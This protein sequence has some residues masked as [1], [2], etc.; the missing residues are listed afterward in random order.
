M[1][2]IMGFIN[3]LRG[4]CD[5]KPLD[6]QSWSHEGG[7]VR[8]KLGQASELSTRGGAVYLE[9]QGLD[10]PVLVVR[11]DDDKYAAFA[12]KC[13]HG[14][15][16]LDPV[17]GQQVLRC[18]SLGHAQYDYDGKVIKGPAKESISRYQTEVSDGDLVIKL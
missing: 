7:T 8:V 1:L 14:G 13:T 16:K 3:S 6:A 12:N 18:C 11:T 9:G 15:R 5:T 4:K 17:S 2:G 10:K